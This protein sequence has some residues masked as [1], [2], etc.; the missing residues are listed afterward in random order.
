MFTFISKKDFNNL[1]N[2]L[3]VLKSKLTKVTN[4]VNVLQTQVMELNLKRPVVLSSAAPAN[5]SSITVT[6]M[7]KKRGRPVGSTNKAKP[8]AKP[9]K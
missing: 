1:V 5:R 8:K 3:L 9:K 2:E 6:A 7:P 4:E